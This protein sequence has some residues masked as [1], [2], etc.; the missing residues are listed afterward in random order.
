MKLVKAVYLALEEMPK[1]ERFSLTSQISRAVVSIPSNIAEGSG[2]DSNKEFKRFL[3]I[4][5]GSCYEVE[6]QLILIKDLL[7]IETAEIISECQ[8][9]QRMISGFAKS[10]TI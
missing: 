3:N 8:S 9:I 10:L 6:T 5:L 1:D 2:R 4:S 7:R